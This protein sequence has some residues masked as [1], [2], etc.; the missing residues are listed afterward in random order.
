MRV[1]LLF[2]AAVVAMAGCAASSD[3]APDPPETS[4]IDETSLEAWRADFLAEGE[5]VYR[6][7]CAQC[8]APGSSDAPAVGVREDWDDRSRLWTAVLFRHARHGYLAMPPRGGSLDMTEREVDAAAEY[9][10]SVTYPE[11]QID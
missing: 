5:A 3:V 1:R 6:E 7:R 11:L 2:F 4:T 9:M 10:L 8:H